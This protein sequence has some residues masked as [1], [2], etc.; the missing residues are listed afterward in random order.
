MDYTHY[1]LLLLVAG[2]ALLLAEVFIP[3]GGLILVMA[4]CCIAG[5]LICAWNA[6]W[7]SNPTL[8]WAYLAGV[9][10]LLPVVGIG[11]LSI[12]PRTSFGRR[13][14]PEPPRPEELRPYREEEERLSRL[15][16]CKARTLTLLNPGGLVTAEGERLHAESEGMLIDP[17]QEVEIVAVKGNRVVVRL[18]EP[19]RDELAEGE[20][21]SPLDFDVPQS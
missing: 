11:A 15:V 5:S 9:L 12:L 13:I 17:G 8:W 10:I 6:W 18:L 7:T 4:L 14:M 20:D 16:G 2:I 19:G 21:V 1:A 3:S